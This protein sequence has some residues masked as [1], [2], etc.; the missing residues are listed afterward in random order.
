M[1]RAL[2]G[3]LVLTLLLWGSPALAQNTQCRTAPVGTISSNC[4]SEAFVTNSIAADTREK[5]TAART[6]YVRTDGNDSCDGKTNAGGSSGACAFLTIQKAV[7]VTSALDINIYNV[8]IQVGAG[9]Y[10]G[11]ATVNGPWLGSGT[12]TLTG[13]TTTPS[14]VVISTTSANC[15]TVK[16]GGYLIV[17][18]FKLTSA[19]SGFLLVTTNFGRIDIN[20]KMEFGAYAFGGI[21]NTLGG[22]IQ[23][24]ATA[25]T[26]SGGGSG[27]FL[28][29]DTDAIFTN[30][31]VTTWTVSTNITVTTFATGTN[32]G[33]LNANSMTFSIGAFT[34]TGT[35]F[36]AAN[37]GRIN[38]SGGGAGFFPGTV[39]GTGTNFGAAPWGLYL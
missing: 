28:A 25:V 31:V 26:I 23:N 1:K 27:V 35:R 36:N 30:Q 32:G 13:D 20:N 33:Y 9:T 19:T 34:V 3:P 39:A 15:V 8:T 21:A 14:N 7:D 11:G 12:V 38:T 16:N 37:G 22:I 29:N 18:G 10:T 6:Y 4:A 5:L 2:L 24:F 17:Q